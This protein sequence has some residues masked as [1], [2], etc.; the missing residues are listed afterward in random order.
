MEN[1][2]GVSMHSCYFTIH[3]ELLLP[4][5]PASLEKQLGSQTATFFINNRAALLSTQLIKPNPGDHIFDT[6]HK[7]MGH[8]TRSNLNLRVT[9]KWVPGH[10]GAAGNEKA[11]ERAKKAITEG[12]HILEKISQLVWKHHGSVM[13]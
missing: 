9:L 3:R 13:L 5:T 12:T 1:W 6:F 8:L 11:D 7:Y 4:Q 10:R 2:T